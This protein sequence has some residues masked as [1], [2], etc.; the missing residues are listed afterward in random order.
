VE[1]GFDGVEDGDA[2]AVGELRGAGMA[3]VAG[4]GGEKTL[5]GGAVV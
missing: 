2:F 4:A 3:H 5:R 1:R